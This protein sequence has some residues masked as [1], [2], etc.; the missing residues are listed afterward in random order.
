MFF[1]SLC[2][3]AFYGNALKLS[4]KSTHIPHPCCSR[5]PLGMSLCGE[6]ICWQPMDVTEYAANLSHTR[7]PHRVVVCFYSME[8]SG[9]PLT[10]TGKSTYIA[11]SLCSLRPIGVSLCG[12]QICWLPM[13]KTEY[14]ANL[15]RTRVPYRDMVCLYSME[16]SG[17]A[18]NLTGKSTHLTHPRCSRRPLGMGLCGESICWKRLDET[19]NVEW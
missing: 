7:V 1:I 6:Q 9:T 17:T 4:G 11:H 18:L 2:L 5:R 8:F 10:L 14:G 13:D 15:S 19:E 16:F 3:T 12:E